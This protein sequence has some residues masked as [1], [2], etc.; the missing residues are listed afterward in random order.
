[1]LDR[2]LA[3][4]GYGSQQ[5]QDP[6]RPGRPDNL[7]QPADGAA[8]RDFGAHGAFDGRAHGRSLQLWLAQHPAVSAGAA[9]GTAPLGGMLAGRLAR[10]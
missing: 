3:R 8:G 10:R 5:T 9:V 1:V 4:T 2:Y 6:V 7:T